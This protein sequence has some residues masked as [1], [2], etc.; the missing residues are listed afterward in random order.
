MAE[1]KCEK[2]GE[3]KE[4]RCKP[5]KCPRCGEQGCMVKTENKTPK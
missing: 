3:V 1:F 4:G 5:R 2:C